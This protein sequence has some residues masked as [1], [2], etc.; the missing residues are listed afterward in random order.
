M[1]L[2]T[3]I[4]WLIGVVDRGW[5]WGGSVI[6]LVGVVD[7]IDVIDVVDDCDWCDWCNDDCDWCDWCGWYDSPKTMIITI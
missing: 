5:C 4:D 7:V 2:M 1:W 6:D 3:V